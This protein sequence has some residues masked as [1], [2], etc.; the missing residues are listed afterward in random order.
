MPDHTF[1]GLWVPQHILPGRWVGAATATTASAWPVASVEV[2]AFD[3]TTSYDQESTWPVATAEVTGFAPSTNVVA[4][5]AWPSATVEVT[6]H[7]VTTVTSNASTWPVASVDVTGFAPSTAY[8]SFQ[9]DMYFH[10]VSLT[11][12]GGGGFRDSPY[13]LGLGA[14]QDPSYSITAAGDFIQNFDTLPGLANPLTNGQNWSTS[15]TLSSDGSNVDVIYM[16]L[17]NFVGQPSS[18]SDYDSLLAGIVGTQDFF[19]TEFSVSPPIVIQSSVSEPNV[20]HPWGGTPATTTRAQFDAWMDHNLST[21]RRNWFST[22]ATDAEADTP[23]GTYLVADNLLFAIRAIR[24]TALNEHNADGWFRDD[25]PHGR[26]DWYALLGMCMFS[27]EKN[28]SGLFGDSIAFPASSVTWPT[29]DGDANNN[30]SSL[31]STNAT[32]LADRIADLVRGNAVTPDALQTTDVS[33]STGSGS[34]EIDIIISSLPETPTDIEYRLDGGTWTSLGETTTGTYAITAPAGSTSYTIEV[35]LVNATGNGQESTNQSVTSA[36]STADSAWPSASI[37]V[38]GFAPTSA[39]TVTSAWP[40]AGIEV[41]S[42]VPNTGANIAS[43]W[44]SASVEITGFTPTTSTS[45][46]SDWPA[47]SVEVTSFVPTTTPPASEPERVEFPGGT[48]IYNISGFTGSQTQFTLATRI[49]PRTGFDNF[50]QI[51]TGPFEIFIASG[52]GGAGERIGLN[53]DGNFPQADLVDGGGSPIDTEFSILLVVDGAGIS[54]GG[55]DTIR[56]YIDGR[57]AMTETSA[58]AAQTVASNHGFLGGQFAT[59]PTL[60]IRRIWA[61][62][63]VIDDYTAFFNADD[64]LRALTGTGVVSGVT[65]D[66]WQ[67]GDAATWNGGSDQNSTSYTVGSTFT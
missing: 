64:T 13:Y 67:E 62:Y 29:G 8:L 17:F 49:T 18:G 36:A 56:C 10:V 61:A 14:A 66:F 11:I 1:P 58:I 37:E 44:P 28:R 23:A 4:R 32:A 50:E 51:S 43:S 26:A 12:D 27:Y 6:G 2:T 31:F 7:V 24:G 30:I 16:D 47:A 38:T 3:V 25:A 19:D 53:I 5:S 33:F 42:F 34:A 59:G 35:R 41:T 46:N 15:T 21:T 40:V 60:G 63:D 65:P 45:V 39:I 22:M 57:L 9:Q 48:G 52:G 55:G 54:G 20:S